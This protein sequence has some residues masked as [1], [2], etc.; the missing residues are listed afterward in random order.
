[1]DE[2][3]EI[4]LQLQAKL[5]RMLQD[6]IIYRIGG[7]NPIKIDVR[8]IVATNRNLEQMVEQKLF[9]TDLY[10]RLRVIPIK[11][12]PLS[13]RKEDV[14]PLIDFFVKKYNIQYKLNRQLS[15]SAYRALINYSWPGNVRELQNTIEYLLV[16][17][18]NDLIRLEDI[19]FTEK[20][21]LQDKVNLI[22]SYSN[23][24]LKT[25]ID[26]FEKNLIITT[27]EKTKS[28][29]EMALLLGTDRSTIIRKLQ[30]YGIKTNF[31]E[32]G[33]I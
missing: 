5:L 8:V 32:N 17:A 31:K 14:R 11:I 3:A 6:H 9:R 26:D 25:A 19:P 13:M 4:P 29:L 33:K 24:T 28:T 10:Y 16:T 21:D 18:S 23:C 2:I 20:R 7:K 15:T 30:K 22:S 1:L 27:M 12:P